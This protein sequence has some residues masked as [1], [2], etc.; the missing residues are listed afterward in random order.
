M[1]HHSYSH[2]TSPLNVSDQ[3]SHPYKNRKSY[4]S[5]YLN[6]YIFNTQLDHKGYR[7]EWMQTF[8]EFNALLIYTWKSLRFIRLFPNFWTL[9]PFQ[10]N[11]FQSSYCQF[12]LHPDLDTW[13]CTEFY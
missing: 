6:L 10:R 13:T 3:V 5:V 2:P 9:P 12:V 1:P 7:N 8:P 4:S 11:Y